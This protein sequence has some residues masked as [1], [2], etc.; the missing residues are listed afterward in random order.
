MTDDLTLD[1]IVIETPAKKKAAPKK[2]TTSKTK[3]KSTKTTDKFSKLVIVESPAK[4]KTIEKYLGSDYKVLS[5]YG[6]IRDL[7]TSG[8]GRLGIDIENGFVPKYTNDKEKK[9][10]ISNLKKAAKGKEVF[11]ASDPDREGEAISW[12]IAEVLGLDETLNNRIVFN[13]ITKEAIT[14]ALENPRQIDMDVVHSQ[15]TRRM[16]D[17][18]IGFKLSS[19]LKS[20]IKSKSA[21][22]VQSVALKLIC[23]RQKE[24]D[25]FIPEEYYTIEALF[26]EQG[27]EFEASLTKHNNRKIELKNLQQAQ[28]VN[29]NLNKEFLIK[30][31][32]VKSK[33]TNPKPTFITS[34]L[35]QE[36]YSKLGFNSKRTMRIAQG[37][38]EGVKVG[39]ETQG[40]ITY[41]RTDSTRLNDG[42]VHEAMAYIK[43]SFAKEYVGHYHVKN[44]AGNVQDAH[45]GIRPTDINRTPASIKA[46]LSDDQF[47]LYELI[48]SRTLASLMAPAINESTNILLD[49][50]NYEFSASGS[51]LVFDGYKKVYGKFESNNDTI[52]PKLEENQSIVSR[53]I[54]LN[55]HFTKG[56]SAYTESSLIKELEELKIGRPS[57]YASIIDTLKNRD[58]V[59]YESRKFAPTQ[60]GVLTDESLNQF[61]SD[62]INVSYTAN[63]EDELD[64]IADDKLNYVGV[65]NDFW[66]KF[67]PLLEKA[68]TEMQKLEAEP[69]GET[70]PECGSPMVFRKGRFGTFEACSNYPECKH[71]KKDPN[72]KEPEKTGEICPKCGG[73]LVRRYSPKSK[74]YFVGCSNYP[75]CRYI[76]PTPDEIV[77]GESCP[78]CGKEVVIRHG[79]FGKFKCCVDYPKC[80]TIIKDDKKE[81]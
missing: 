7:S 56:P 61:F 36:A 6:H 72:I 52:L 57:T 15:E 40:L 31:I 42:F 30:T 65:L 4:S 10:V 75:K 43:D 53:K 73:E 69:T 9:E 28:D 39:K 33:K 14:K 59:T 23:D 79:R 77:E 47:K 5:S 78:T 35:Q 54:D 58:Y 2:K 8:K 17:R 16:L 63:M 22:R 41:M 80:K 38:Y 51:V 44:S 66:G 34:T 49:N 11:L 27:I 46:Y 76:Q 37:L 55:Q 25:A 24:I 74:D 60:Q 48:Y 1:D 13:E 20:K 32:N 21:G 19:L 12:H 45:E 62:I 64:E 70:C 68:K 71:I 18:I 50:N 26:K 29:K 81:K 67:E 3:T